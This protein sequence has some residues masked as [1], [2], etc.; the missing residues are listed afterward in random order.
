MKNYRR[1]IFFLAAILISIPAIGQQE[2]RIR[3]RTVDY[4]EYDRLMANLNYATDKAGAVTALFEFVGKNFTAEDEEYFN[5]R[6]SAV[7]FL[8]TMGDYN[9]ALLRYQEAIEAFEKHYPFYT[10]GYSQVSPSSVGYLYLGVSTVYKYLHL[11]EKN[12]RYLESKRALLETNEVPYIRQAFYSDLG[13]SLFKAGQYEKAIEVLLQLKK[14]VESGAL[15]QPVQSGDEVYKIDPTWPEETRQQILKAKA[16]YEESM[17]KM[18]E[19]LVVYQRLAYTNMLSQAYFRQFR[20]EESI[21]YAKQAADDMKSVHRYAQES[22]QGSGTAFASATIPDSIRKQMQ[23]GI[24]YLKISENIGG[25]AVPLIVSALKS[26]QL[27]LAEQYA[28]QQIEQCLFQQLSGD[29]PAAEKRYADLFQSLETM[30]GIKVY[31]SAAEHYYSWINPYYLNLKVKSGQPDAALAQARSLIEVEEKNLIKN[32]QYFTENEKR[33]F[34]KNYTHELERYYSLLLQLTENGR[35]QTGELLN[36]ILQ[37]KGLILDATRE[38]ERQLRKIKD[39]VTLAQIAEIKRLRDRLAIFNGQ[40]S[41]SNQA[42]MDSVNRLSIRI[43]DLER[44][45][46][47]KLVPINILKNIS[48]QDVQARLKKG[49]VYLEILRLQRD[50]FEFDKPQVQYWAFVIKPG[51]A[52]PGFFQ[53]AAGEAF[54]GRSLRNYQNRLRNQLEDMESYNLYWR[55]IS[56]QMRGAITAIISADGVY[57]V[58][59]PV[60]LQNPATGKFVLDEVEVKRVSTGRDLLSTEVAP[61][62]N[63]MIVLV[64]N[65]QFDMSRKQGANV[66]R[67][68]A[69]VPVEANETTRSGIMALPGTKKEIELIEQ[70]ATSDGFISEM[71][72][73][74]AANESN[75]KKLKSPAVLHL[76]THGEFNQLSTADT[77]LKSK[78]ILAGAADPEPLKV[79]DFTLY[80]DGFLT[81]Y[82][83][84]QLELS[85]TRLVVLSACETG[86]GEIQS[87]EGVW[88]LQ[89]AFQLAG[90]KTVM[91]SLWK[92]SDEATVTYMEAFYKEYLTAKDVYQAY[93]AAMLATRKHYLHPYYWGAFTLVGSN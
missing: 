17:K 74:A 67:S 19:Q 39:K 51:E 50:N 56:D 45:V 92:I 63:K 49:E 73:G 12:I 6:F 70:E 11:Y 23:N 22:L 48:W 33:E 65:P 82:E 9:H 55:N 90:A 28:T 43:A 69:V 85:E 62:Q 68:N 18:Q 7:N 37:T 64:G 72:T 25:P 78:L 36:K 71:L 13:E 58:V 79:T 61:A 84:T 41:G 46:N 81:A 88:G 87:G 35:D 10:R 75:V 60:A 3:S 77:Y 44:A 54:E 42:M 29:Y 16:Q 31:S 83:V 40:L 91:G 27:T 66:Y 86:L 59:N 30:R 21:P 53:I 4:A 1:F 14:L 34:F 2:S 93:Q 15:K 8:V 32:F 89:R 20:F 76:A 5:A 24:D 52:K 47:L 57:H 26:N 38:Q 80:E